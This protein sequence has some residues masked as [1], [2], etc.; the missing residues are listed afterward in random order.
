V[1]SAPDVVLVPL[2]A[3]FRDEASWAVYVVRGGRADLRRIELGR[4]GQS[5]AA[6]K[7]GLQPGE[8]VVFHPSERISDGT[9]VVAD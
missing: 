5:Q 3:L 6:V 8:R 1:W 7:G 4:R 9:R 2:G